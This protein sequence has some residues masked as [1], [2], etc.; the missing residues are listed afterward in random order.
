ML[1]QVAPGV[2]SEKE[3]KQGSA[4]GT[5]TH[6]RQIDKAI[7]FNF[8]KP[9]ERCEPHLKRFAGRNCAFAADGRIS[10]GSAAAGGIVRSRRT[11][12][13][14]KDP[15]RLA[16]LCVRGR[17]R[18][19]RKIRGGWRKSFVRPRCPRHRNSAFT[20]DGGISHLYPRQVR[21]GWRNLVS[22]R[23]RNQPQIR[24]GWR[25][26][27]LRP[28]C[29]TCICILQPGELVSLVLFSQDAPRVV[30]DNDVHT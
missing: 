6:P 24:G 15:R 16:E 11:A 23:R 27:F 18:N 1:A 19:Q 7:F 21:G 30:R 13:T 14:A 5:K 3:K 12:K 29:P 22:S 10:Q 8:L 25:K 4:G 17:R 28:R 26:S 20:A 2:T 9:F